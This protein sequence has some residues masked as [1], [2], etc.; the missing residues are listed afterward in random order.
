MESWRSQVLPKRLGVSVSFAV[1]SGSPVDKLTSQAYLR[2]QAAHRPRTA[3]GYMS[4][5]KLY[6]AFIMWYSLPLHMV[7]SVLAFL[8]FLVEH[9]SK[10]HTLTSYISVLSHV[11]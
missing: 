3:S 10:S 1:F 6:L 9:G 7:D 8:E 5:F 2:I 11:V 4:K